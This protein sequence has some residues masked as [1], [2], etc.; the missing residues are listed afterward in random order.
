MKTQL[1]LF[2]VTA[3]LLLCACLTSSCST[4]DAAKE[5]PVK[6]YPFA[7][8]WKGSGVDSEGYA[9]E[10]FA[11]VIP[12]GGG[13]YR[14]LIL[15]KLDTQKDPLHVMEGTLE[16]NIYTYTADD[17]MYTGQGRLKKDSFEGRYQGPIDGT[18][19][20]QRIAEP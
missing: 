19:T 6:N 2:V 5:D 18:Y 4:S 7:G 9:F 1:N 13:T 11:T 15:D 16:A 12:L 20:M 3:C 14:I 8:H 17:G 10:F